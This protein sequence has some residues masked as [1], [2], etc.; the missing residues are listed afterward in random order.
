MRLTDVSC[1]VDVSR[2]V[3]AKRAPVRNAGLLAVE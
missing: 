3:E 2:F 1:V